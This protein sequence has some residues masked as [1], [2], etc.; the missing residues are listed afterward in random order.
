M[1]GDQEYEKIMASLD[2]VSRKLDIQ[3]HAARAAQIDMA[4]LDRRLTEMK[5]QIAKV[6]AA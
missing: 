3:I 2:S 6:V 1:A 4:R 5:E